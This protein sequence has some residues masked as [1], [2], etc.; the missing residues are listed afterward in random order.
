MGV[1]VNMRMAW[2][3][4]QPW[5]CSNLN[6][7]STTQPYDHLTRYGTTPSQQGITQPDTQENTAHNSKTHAPSSSVCAHIF[8]PSRGPRCRLCFVSPVSPSP[9][10]V[11]TCYLLK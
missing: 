7:H 5:N 6:M 9:V 3:F 1:E 2:A 11:L 10:C 4:V 8:S